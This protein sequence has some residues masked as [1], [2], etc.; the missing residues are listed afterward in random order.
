MGA[1]AVVV[2]MSKS[3]AVQ[4]PWRFPRRLVCS[5]P[6]VNENVVLDIGAAVAERRR[7]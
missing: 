1:K 3:V 2:Q 7:K 6:T 4:P 5:G